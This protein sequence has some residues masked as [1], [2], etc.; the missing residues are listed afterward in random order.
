MTKAK[1][2][3]SFPIPFV[4]ISSV[5]VTAVPGY[6]VPHPP[7]CSTTRA[8]SRDLAGPVE[9][10]GLCS[11]PEAVLAQSGEARV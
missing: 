9:L 6:W 2:V 1:V 5:W 3:S 7:D 10:I 8:E 4:I 11:G